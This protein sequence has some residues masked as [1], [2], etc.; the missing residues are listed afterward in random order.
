[1]FKYQ[2]LNK[3]IEQY[4]H[5]PEQ[6]TEAWKALRENFIGGS[7]VSTILKQ[8]KNKTIS[9]LIMGKLGFDTF[10]GNVITH[11]GNV[12]EEAIRL[13]CEEVFSCSIRETGSIPYKDGFLSYS[14]DG[15]A[16]VP[17][18]KLI[19]RFGSLTN[20]L[21]NKDPTQLVLF[22]FKCPHSRVASNEIPEHYWPQVNIGMNIIDIMETAIFVQAT[23]R[24]CSFSSLKH[25]RQHN[26]YGHFKRADTT[27]PPVEC[28]FMVIYDHDINNEEYHEGLKSALLE[29]GEASEIHLNNGKVALDLGTVYDTQ[30]LEEVLGNCV[31]KKFKIDYCFRHM[32]NQDV[33]SQGDYKLSF[34][35]ESLRYRATKE[36][37]NQSI[38]HKHIIGV[39]PFKLLNIH[40]TPVAKNP[41]Y[42]QET[43]AHSKAIDVLQCIK[44]LKYND[45]KAD[46]VKCIRRYKL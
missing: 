37:Q 1:M 40:M 9:K 8:N 17:T 11:W 20:G 33:F 22:E 16:V 4:K 30:L 35:D 15:L 31:S 38:R 29:I 7:E 25:D 12:F 34:Y 3:F 41:N 13:H 14:P 28:G 6:G 5:L 45:C 10:K 26:S 32:Y 43:N 24:R 36:L 46:V 21:N 27:N 19:K 23:Y 2:N 42:I 39:M 44:D 18:N